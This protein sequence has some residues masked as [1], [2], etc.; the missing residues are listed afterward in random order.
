MKCPRKGNLQRKKVRSCL[1]IGRG[2]VGEWVAREEGV[3]F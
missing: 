3:S 1:G 2:E